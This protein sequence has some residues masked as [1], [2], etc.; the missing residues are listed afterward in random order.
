METTG[1]LQAGVQIMELEIEGWKKV[2]K[3]FCFPQPL[4]SRP[5][6]VN[7]ESVRGEFHQTDPEFGGS[8]YIWAWRVSYCAELWELYWKTF[9]QER[10]ALCMA[11][12]KLAAGFTNQPLWRL[13]SCFLE[14]LIHPE[15]S[16]S[17]KYLN[18]RACELEWMQQ[19]I[20][21]FTNF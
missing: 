2:L 21:F 13:V 15:V 20:S 1:P 14:K 12:E 11:W 18:Q 7:V 16:T 8:K 3:E 19:S 4:S 9:P 5:S 10:S 17:S 6:G